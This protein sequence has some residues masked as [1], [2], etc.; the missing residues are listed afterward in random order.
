[1]QRVLWCASRKHSDTLLRVTG[2]QGVNRFGRHHGPEIGVI[3]VQ[4]T[5]TGALQL[6]AVSKATGQR[7]YFTGRDEAE[8]FLRSVWNASVEI[9]A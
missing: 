7:G 4:F 8:S 3:Y 1:M 5:Q 6:K 9:A 2:V